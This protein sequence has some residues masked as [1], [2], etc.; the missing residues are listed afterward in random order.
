MMKP[1]IL[2]LCL[3]IS[4][5]VWAETTK[6]MSVAINWLQL[7]DAGEYTKSWQQA[8]ALFKSQLSKANWKSALNTVR[9]PLGKVATREQISA[10]AYSSLP[11][12]PQGKYLIVQ[13]K[14]QF[15]A[16]LAVETLTLSKSSGQWRAVGYFIK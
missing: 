4:C 14:T 12:A 16:R 1:L 3:F 9:A 5:S 8:D 7:I 6:N 13:F 10:N 2:I 15:S 11:G